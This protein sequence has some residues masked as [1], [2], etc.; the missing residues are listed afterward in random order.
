MADG[1][2]VNDRR[3]KCRVCTNA[4]NLTRYHGNPNTK[5]AHREASYRYTIKKYGLSIEQH[6]AMLIKQGYRCY[7]CDTHQDD[8]RF[9]KLSIDHCHKTGVVRKLL[10]PQCNT[11]LGQ[12][13]DNPGTLR[14][15][16]AYLEEQHEATL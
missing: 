4:E 3:A 2:T 9:G 7:I 8:T 12:A 11:A 6:E 16:A 14:R 10:C 15:M 13:R 5:T 1:S